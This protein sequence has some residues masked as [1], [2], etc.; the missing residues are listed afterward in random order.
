M[1]TRTPTM[2]TP[3]TT[4]TRR[5]AGQVATALALA[6][7]GALLL[8]GHRP[9]GSSATAVTTTWAK[10]GGGLVESDVDNNDV[11]TTETTESRRLLQMGQRA[12]RFGGVDGVYATAERD[13]ARA[14]RGRQQG[15]YVPLRRNRVRSDSAL[16][17]SKDSMR[18]YMNRK[19]GAGGGIGRRR[20]ADGS[21]VSRVGGVVTPSL[22]R[23][24][25]GGGGGGGGGGAREGGSNNKSTVQSRFREVYTTGVWLNAEEGHKGRSRSG[26]GSNPGGLPVK[27]DSIFLK[28]VMKRHLAGLATPHIVDVPCGDMAWMPTVLRDVVGLCTL[29]QVDP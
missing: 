17:R 16:D 13:A 6:T 21:T 14:A 8:V 19:L 22:D 18:N 7:L 2:A 24:P 1:N 3:T 9:M 26:Q 25:S 11:A 15:T 10:D 28:R 23:R 4:T 29:N 20:G 5:T 27:Q 12:R